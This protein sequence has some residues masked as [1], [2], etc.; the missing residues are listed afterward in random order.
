M[1]IKVSETS[2]QSILVFSVHF[3]VKK[4]TNSS[5]YLRKKEPSEKPEASQRRNQF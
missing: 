5:L 2:K 1:Y 4:K 3:L